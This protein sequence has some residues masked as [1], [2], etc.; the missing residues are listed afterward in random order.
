MVNLKKI[1]IHDLR[2]SYV[3]L[4]MSKGANFGVIAALIGDTLEQVVKTYTR[5]NE[6]DK[7]KAVS[8]L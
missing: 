2:H 1:R 5:H 4:L 6:D 7:T 8:M 3:T